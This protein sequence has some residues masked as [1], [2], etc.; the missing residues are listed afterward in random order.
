MLRKTSTV[1]AYLAAL[2][3]AWVLCQAHA[4]A[5][6]GIV[7]PAHADPGELVVLRANTTAKGLAWARVPAGT[8]WIAVDGGGTVVFATGRAGDYVFLLATATGDV[9]ALYQHTVTIGTAPGPTPPGPTPPNPPDPNPPIPPPPGPTPSNDMRKLALDAANKL[10]ASARA[11]AA[12][13][14]AIFA[15]VADKI[16]GEISDPGVLARATRGARA[17]ALPPARDAAWDGW[18]A[19]IG[20][21]IND[22]GLQPMSTYKQWWLEIAAGLKEVK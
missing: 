9:P 15:R 18:A 14:S 11:D 1:A 3:L 20:K 5:A 8:N 7:G 13:V 16:P 17:L 10:P 4:R 22:R 19:E 6:E 12:I 21:A 2:A